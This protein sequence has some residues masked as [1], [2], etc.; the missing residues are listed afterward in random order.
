MIKGVV[1]IS[2]INVCIFIKS[3]K[4]VDCAL[5]RLKDVLKSPQTISPFQS[6][7]LTINSIALTTSTCS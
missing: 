7:E 4:Q 1:T 2:K 5:L 6:S 3:F